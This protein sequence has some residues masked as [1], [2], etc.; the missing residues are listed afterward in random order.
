MDASRYENDAEH[1]WHLAVMTILLSEYA[2]SR[3]DLLK[4]LTMVLVHDIVEID[5]GDTFCYSASRKAGTLEKESRAAKR[6]FGILPAEQ[7]RRLMAAWREFEARK[8]PEAKFAAAL[9]RLHPVLHN[10]R[11]RGAAWKKHGVTS[12]QV[13]D[14]NSKI[15]AGAKRLWQFA[16]SLIK[17]SV[18]KGYLR[19]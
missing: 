4:I 6:I 13:F 8:T 15:D 1:S 19:A 11:T 18:R 2:N 3:V 17:D 5:A 16:K 7:A 9:D 14:R 10:Y 12:S